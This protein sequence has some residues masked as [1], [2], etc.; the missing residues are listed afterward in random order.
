MQVTS[1]E[2]KNCQCAPRCSTLNFEYQ[3]STQ[4]IVTSH[5]EQSQ[6]KDSTNETKWVRV[7]R[8]QIRTEINIDL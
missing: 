7:N 2:L 3:S 4:P 8:Q 6:K 5:T 1:Q